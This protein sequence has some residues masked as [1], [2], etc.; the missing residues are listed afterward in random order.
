MVQLDLGLLSLSKEVEEILDLHFD[1]VP[2]A[3][4]FGEVPRVD[5]RW[6]CVSSDPMRPTR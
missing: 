3:A 2:H 6:V 5:G 1:L 4:E